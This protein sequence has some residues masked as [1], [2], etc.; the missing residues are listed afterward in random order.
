[1][2]VHAAVSFEAAVLYIH[3]VDVVNETVTTAYRYIPSI[4]GIDL[5]RSLSSLLLPGRTEP[6]KGEIGVNSDL[7]KTVGWIS[8]I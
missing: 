1:M 2:I 4:E 6:L 5:G 8:S 3:A 7:C